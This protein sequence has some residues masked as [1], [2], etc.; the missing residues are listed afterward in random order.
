MS[1]Q[2]SSLNPSSPRGASYAPA[3]AGFHPG[4]AT[5][6]PRE[7]VAYREPAPLVQGRA[8][9]ARIA[10]V[11]LNGPRDII[12]CV[13]A[14][15]PLPP[16]LR[17][18]V[19]ALGNFDGF[20]LGHQAVVA[21]AVAMARQRGVAAIVGT[22][23]PH[24]VDHFKPGAPASRLSTLEQRRR[25][26]TLAGV[27]AMMVFRFGGAL[28]SVS[29]QDFVET[30]LADAGGVV[31]GENFIFGRG[32]TGDVSSLAKFGKHKLVAAAVA[33]VLLDR[34]IVSSTRIRDALRTGDCAAATRLLSRPFTVKGIFGEVTPRQTGHR[35]HAALH[36]GP[37]L[38]PTPGLYAVRVLR[39]NGHLQA[40]TAHV[41][42]A[43]AA[44]QAQDWLQLS[45][46]SAAP[47]FDECV[48]VAFINKLS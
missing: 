31:T 36:L 42:P 22:F 48:E 8:A 39:A 25:L 37:Y 9:R 35:M 7:P 40:G 12:G 23:D 38:R 27:D 18:A 5:A 20:H 32:R 24:P 26:L 17:G 11:P 45:L 28:A 33:P 34:E 29:P 47:A 30:W 16:H 46:A 21:R 41:H 13:E 14:G 2:Q 6:R 3:L 4:S 15:R 44:N 1:G 19:I 43:N 10:E